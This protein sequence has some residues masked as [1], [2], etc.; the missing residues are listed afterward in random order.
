MFDFL[1]SVEK[2]YVYIIIRII[3]RLH[4]FFVVALRKDIKANLEVSKEKMSES[5]Y[6]T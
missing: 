6:D 4:G 3:R 2:I 1:A 5:T